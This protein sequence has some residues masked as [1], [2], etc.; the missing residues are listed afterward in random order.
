METTETG[1]GEKKGGFKNFMLV[2]LGAGVIALGALSISEHKQKNRLKEDLK[3][4]ITLA[5]EKNMKTCEAIENNLSEISAKEGILPA[6][7]GKE[8]NAT[9]EERIQRSIKAIETVMTKNRELIA[10]LKNTVGERDKKLLKF[11]KQMARL[12]KRLKE[13]KTQTESLTAQTESLQKDLSLANQ[14][15]ETI[16][17]E[18]ALKEKDLQE[19]ADR[20]EQQSQV[21]SAKDKELHTG[22]YAVGDY[23]ELKDN[24]VLGK[25]GGIIG[26]GSTKTLKKD[27][28]RNYFNKIDIYNYTSIPVFSRNAE[29]ITNHTTGSYE[30]V[31]GPND[32]IQWIK[33]TNPEKFW[34]NSKY[35]VIVKKG[36]TTPASASIY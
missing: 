32:E 19:K 34:E 9:S 22:Y 12:D 7:A 14:M 21:I 6:P 16:A 20:I 27:F 30:I 18:L 4:Q 23:K 28:N 8:V 31:H 11:E 5:E 3:S 1:S 13:Y 26:L 29:I 35:L 15:R 36:E 10:N 25:E 17:D 2:F 33:I 24:D